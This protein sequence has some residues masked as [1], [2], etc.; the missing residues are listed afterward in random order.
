MPW[1]PAHMFMMP[2]KG[3]MSNHRKYQCRLE[4][5]PVCKGLLW[6][7]SFAKVPYLG[8]PYVRCAKFALI[9]SE[10]LQ[11]AGRGIKVQHDPTWS[12]MAF[13]GEWRSNSPT[14]SNKLRRVWG[15]NRV[16]DHMSGF[17]RSRLELI[18]MLLH[19]TPP[20]PAPPHMDLFIQVQ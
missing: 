1:K 6:A 20:Y 10:I 19:P 18:Q 2:V 5:L 14:A 12:N 17:A 11:E 16:R 7:T 9:R 8:I 13:N 15:H 4:N 3:P